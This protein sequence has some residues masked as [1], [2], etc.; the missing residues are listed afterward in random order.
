METS[1]VR[2]SQT[3]KPIMAKKIAIQY[4]KTR[5]DDNYHF[6]NNYYLITNDFT[7]KSESQFHDFPIGQYCKASITNPIEI[8]LN[9]MEYLVLSV[10]I[11]LTEITLLNLN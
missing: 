5:T 4:Y 3:K 7:T 11:I 8:L 6:A 10:I 1:F 9:T 2:W